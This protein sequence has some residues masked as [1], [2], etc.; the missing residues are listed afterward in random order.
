MGLDINKDITKSSTLPADFYTS[1][2]QFELL[3]EKVFAKSWHWITT[4]NEIPHAGSTYPFN[5]YDRFLEEPLVFVKDQEQQIRC[6][7]N[8]CTHRGN[9]LVPNQGTCKSLVCGY[10]GRKFNLKGEFEFMPEFKEAKNFPCEHD[11]L[12]EV[13]FAKFHN[14]L[15]T[16]L[17]PAFDFS[18]IGD[19]MNK[20]M[21]FLPIEN[22]KFDPSST[23]DYLVNSNWAL[24]CDN[25]LEGFHI[26]FVHKD[27]N[28]VLDYK[29]YSS[30]LSSYCNL[31]I[32][33]ADESTI[34]FDLP[35]DHEDYGKKVAAYYFWLFPNMMFN[36]YPWGLSINIVKPLETDKCKVSFYTYIYDS[37]KIQDSA[38][39]DIDKVEREDEAIV[40]T[41]QKGLKSRFYKKGRFSPTREKGV[42]H[43]HSLIE[44][45]LN[46]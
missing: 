1:K 22:F 6:L 35:E 18:E 45:F 32:G 3:K 10:H 23:R 7:S 9:L 29:N 13:P 34:A 43:F 42:H 46:R 44:E 11:N 28:A 5:L 2:E 31:Q 19:V 8:V 14:H 37:S 33:I 20:K 26:P 24:Y 15:F 12:A 4:E 38:G 41:V 25:Y 30:E 17:D 21:G 27:L 40:E 36:F 39:A 16:S